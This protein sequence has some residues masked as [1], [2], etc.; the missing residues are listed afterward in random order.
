MSA[1]VRFGLRIPPCASATEIARCVGAAETAGFDVAWIPD[2]Q[3]LWRDVWA[4]M[5]VA[6]ASTSTIAL[7]TCVTNVETRHA[8]VTAAAAATIEEL[9]PGR[10]ILGLGTGDSAIKTLGLR[11][12]RLGRMREQLALI[13]ALLAGGSAEFDGR[14][15]RLRRPASTPVPL[16]MAATAPKALALAG[17]IAD[18]VIVV[19]GLSPSLIAR[20]VEQI[21]DGARR[22]GRR[23]EGVD[24][25]F[26]TLCHIAD[27]ELEAVRAV[28]PYVVAIGQTGGAEI[29]RAAGIELDVP[30]GA[31]GIYPDMSHAED[32]DAA[33][34]IAGRWVSDDMA[35][36]Y[37]EAFCLVGTA[38]ACAERLR[39]A[40]EHG[41]RSFY[42]RHFGSYTLPD[43]L[44]EL[45]GRSIIPRLR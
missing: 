20:T 9:A 37:A 1:G 29:L 11:P 10:T 30:A 5:A 21:G 28:K 4:T 12:T 3:F 32:W 16:Y 17:E 31:G 33:V 45:F 44:L 25:C 13:R 2:S 39:E 26:G 41:A 18:G 22:G 35:A 27:D 23:P 6:A 34:E 14:P 7:G 8:S 42:I 40:V 43:A 36:R 24:V 19:R 15:M 38:D